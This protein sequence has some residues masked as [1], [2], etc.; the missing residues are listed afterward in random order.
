[1]ESKEKSAEAAARIA[2]AQK[3]KA[4]KATKAAARIA[5][6][7]KEKGKKRGK[8]I[9]KKG[10]FVVIFFGAILLT[11]TVLVAV[12]GF[13][14]APS[15][16]SDRTVSKTGTPMDNFPDDQ[17]ETFCGTGDAKSNTFV[18]EYKIPTVCTQPLAITVTPNGQIWFVES[19]VGRIANFDPVTESF[20]EFDNPNWP[21]GSRSMNW[22]ID[23]SSD[24]SLWYTDGTSDSLWRFGINDESYTAITFPTS[25]SGSLPQKLK[26]DG[27]SAFV[28][29]FTGGKLTVFD[30]TQDVD[31]VKY[32]SIVNPIPQSFTGDFDLDSNNNLW[33][34]NWV[35]DNTG[36]LAKFDFTRYQQETS[37]IETSSENYVEAF[38]FPNDLNTAN[39]L[40]IDSNDNVW[41]LDTSSSFFFKF[42]PLTEEFTKY[43]TNVP[44]LISYGNATGVITNPISRPYWSTFD[45]YGNLIFTEQT[46]NRIAL[47]DV[48]K[49]SLI[50]YMVPS[51]NPNWADCGD[52][53]D[54]GVAQIFG[55]S[56]YDKQI[57]FT[58]W[59][60]N[61]IGVIDTDKPLPFS[62][63]TDTEIISVK[64]GESAEFVLTV[65]YADLSDSINSDFLSSHTASSTINFTDIE[66]SSTRENS[67]SNTE[68]ILVEI[69]ASNTS[70]SG[71]YKALIGIGNDE[72]A[73]SKFIDVIIES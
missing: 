35:P 6:A 73:V 65:N 41:I 68:Q 63:E 13:D 12:S 67:Q 16:E 47:F 42:D 43:I 36:I 30:I 60:E 52:L 17:R 33:Y 5:K 3:E 66:I 51:K 59:V 50:E 53:K 58:E 2:K 29:D 31:E 8:S 19:N 46:S 20:T 64:K 9:N 34:T 15:D 7:E 18:T 37:L 32:I 55:I 4:K 62:V 69:R 23:Y 49:E 26:I 39:G 21:E 72:V 1:M 57:W 48:N 61:N 25:E 54:C 28:N 38:E 24:D 70:L 27:S 14:F 44:P 45:N 40:S 11:S 56:V 10:I 71:S 22:G